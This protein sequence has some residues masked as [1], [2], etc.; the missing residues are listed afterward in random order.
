MKKGCTANNSSRMCSTTHSFPTES[1]LRTLWDSLERNPLER[2]PPGQR[3]P[4][5]E[6]RQ[7]WYQAARQEVTSYRDPLWT[8]WHTLLKILPSPKLC[9]RTVKMIHGGP[10]NGDWF[11]S[12]RRFEVKLL[13]VTNFLT[14][15]RKTLLVVKL[16]FWNLSRRDQKVF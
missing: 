15:S 10:K 6:T 14:I 1:N 9:L 2:D 4:Q 16:R 12:S 11:I 7:T 13:K 3:P 8:E 5:T